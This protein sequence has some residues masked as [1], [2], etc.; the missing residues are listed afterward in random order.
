MS[1]SQPK[2]QPTLSVEAIVDAATKISDA[3]GFEEISMRRLA[4]EFGVTAMALYGY[5]ETKQHLLELVADRYMTELDLA[6]GEK[7]WQL[8]LARVFASFRGLLVAHPVLA[9]TLTHQTVD[10]PAA[11]RMAD[12]VV[13]ILRDHGFEDEAAI[14]LTIVLASYTVGM[15]LSQHPRA[16][17]K[18]EQRKR[19]R[20]V[21]DAEDLP[22]LSAVAE[23][24]VSWPDGTFQH[25]L[26]QLIGAYASG[27]GRRR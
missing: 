9:H 23:L 11:Y 16:I 1:P 10:A 8:R 17:P 5:V 18:A 22:N 25:G 24:Y 6:E 4:D 7:D 27:K 12:V 2:K 19:V 14:E 26:E 15:V 21:R 3:E 13:G 20:R